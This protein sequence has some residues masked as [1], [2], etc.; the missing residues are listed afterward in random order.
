MMLINSSLSHA[1]ESYWEEL[2]D[3]LDRLNGGRTVL[4]RVP[5][6]F[7]Q[8]YIVNPFQLALDVTRH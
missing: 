5:F 4:V 2:T 1:T 6:A 8:R 3:E 7:T